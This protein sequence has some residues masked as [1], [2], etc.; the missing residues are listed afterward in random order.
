MG[1]S[2]SLRDDA[3]VSERLLRWSSTQ[4]EA[5]NAS[6]QTHQNLPLH[7]APEAA[8]GPPALRP[9]IVHLVQ[10]MPFLRPA[11]GILYDFTIPELMDRTMVLFQGDP[12]RIEGPYRGYR[13]AGGS[14]DSR[15]DG[16]PFVQA[17]T[18]AQLVSGIYSRCLDPL[19]FESSASPHLSKADIFE[20]FVR[21]LLSDRGTS[22]VSI[23]AGGIGHI[24]AIDRYQPGVGTSAMRWLQYLAGEALE[25]KRFQARAHLP[26]PTGSLMAD[27][28]T[29]RDSVTAADRYTALARRVLEVPNEKGERFQ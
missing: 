23:I 11:V 13:F 6:T 19:R 15:Q 1:K 14:K 2:P 8:A 22:T 25:T 20:G 3:A 16:L 9:R 28:R 4:N 5:G 17:F 29:I 27:L 10:V 18:A 24:R 7:A 21:R 12:H 26:P